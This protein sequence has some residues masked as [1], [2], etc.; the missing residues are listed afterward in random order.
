[1]HA[2]GA[3]C[4]GLC[5]GKL[6]SPAFTGTVHSLIFGLTLR[7]FASFALNACTALG[8]AARL[9]LH[10]RVPEPLWFAEL[11]PLPLIGISDQS[12]SEDLELALASITLVINEVIASPAAFL[13]NMLP[14]S[15][16]P[17]QQ[18]A[19]RA[20]R[21]RSPEPS[22]DRFVQH[23]TIPGQKGREITPCLE[24][25]VNK[26]VVGPKRKDRQNRLDRQRWV[27]P[28]M[29]LSDSV[30]ELILVFR[31]GLISGARFAQVPCSR[32]QIK[33]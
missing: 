4:E 32:F 15:P 22:N 11:R 30:A 7:N 17:P 6:V 19:L 9:Q 33:G 3:A 28:P 12:A 24:L 14:V 18:P 1:V 25:N 5:C 16:V 29:T 10:F 23:R 13:G 27:I 8:G 2:C 20:L 26:P 31:R 21:A